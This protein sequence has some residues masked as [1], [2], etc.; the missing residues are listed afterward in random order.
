M[1]DENLEQ[2]SDYSE[3]KQ[4]EETLS[5]ASNKVSSGVSNFGKGVSSGFN[6]GLKSTKEKTDDNNIPAAKNQNPA[7]GVA[8]TTKSN[9][10]GLPNENDDGNKESGLNKK[11]NN[12]SKDKNKK[13]NKT[14]KSNVKK[15]TNSKESILDKLKEARKKNTLTKK[16]NNVTQKAV[17]DKIKAFILSNPYL[18]VIGGILVVFLFIVLLISLLTFGTFIASK[19]PG[20]L[21]NMPKPVSGTVTSQFAW[22]NF[23]GVAEAHK[24]IDISAK[25]GTPVKA[26][27]KGTITKIGYDSNNG[28]YVVID[29]GL[30]DFDRVSTLYASL[31]KDDELE[32]EGLS[33][34]NLKVG[35]EIGQGTT[36]GYIGSSNYEGG[37]HLHFEILE[38]DIQISPNKL[39][40]YYDPVGSC[41]PVTA[42]KTEL[43]QISSLQCEALV[44][45]ADDDKISTFCPT[46]QICEGKITLPIAPIC[47]DGWCWCAEGLEY[48]YDEILKDDAER[49]EEFTKIT[50]DA[51]L[52]WELNLEYGYFKTSTNPEDIRPGAIAVNKGSV[53][54]CG[55]RYCGHVW[56]VVQV[57]GD[58]IKIYE[59][60]GELGSG[61]CGYIDKTRE[62]VIDKTQGNGGFDGWVYIL[63]CDELKNEEENNKKNEIKKEEL[64]VE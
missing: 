42:E 61:Q 2:A 27:R 25:R 28:Q 59:C 51:Y 45:L 29:H 15:D 5:N 44:P 33:S 19:D 56:T 54:R 50:G 37:D 16:N 63:D 46:A 38:N 23:K 32:N 26:V 55:N 3:S 60:N 21:C 14:D 1:E 30:Y 49:L 62:E 47:P 9:K 43:D 17:G 57:N 6:G 58:N 41:N 13:D 4:V 36:I 52:Y 34:L 35:D 40:E 18:I 12:N 53:T 11:D 10:T 22:R 20:S 39:Y 48:F 7:S 24:G 8:E 31:L 64:K